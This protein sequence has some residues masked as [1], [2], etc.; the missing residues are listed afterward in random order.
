MFTFQVP[1]TLLSETEH[2]QCSTFHFVECAS[3]FKQPRLC[4][5]SVCGGTNVNKNK[6]P[7]QKFLS[8]SKVVFLLHDLRHL[9]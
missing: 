7:V 8:K 4:L 6:A 2:S 3:V 5:H 9:Y 1:V